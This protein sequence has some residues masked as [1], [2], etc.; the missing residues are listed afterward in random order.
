MSKVFQYTGFDTSHDYIWKIYF[1][2]KTL[3]HELPNFEVGCTKYILLSKNSNQ[4]LWNR[5]TLTR[6]YNV[7]IYVLFDGQARIKV[8]KRIEKNCQFKDFMFHSHPSTICFTS[9]SASY[10]LLGGRLVESFHTRS[11]TY[12]VPSMESNFRFLKCF[13]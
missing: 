1:H 13:S 2:F 3:L 11:I 9:R 6:L 5:R 4:K 12:I 10:R 7:Q 8:Q